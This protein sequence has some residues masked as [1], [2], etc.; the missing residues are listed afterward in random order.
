MNDP[1]GAPSRAFDPYQLPQCLARPLVRGWISWMQADAR[2]A[3]VAFRCPGP[4]DDPE[5]VHT[6]LRWLLKEHVKAEEARVA[7]AHGGIWRVV[8]QLLRDRVP[9]QR[10]L[11]EAHD[12]NGVKGFPLTE[13]QVS[14]LVDSIILWCARKAREATHG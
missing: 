1:Q 7:A 13:E 2:L 12:V 6:I 4:A 14:C 9:I 11:A 8:R 10:V 5:A 3:L